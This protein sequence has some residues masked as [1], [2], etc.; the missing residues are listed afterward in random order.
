MS[1]LIDL[2]LDL[3]EHLLRYLTVTDIAN[4]SVT[5]KLHYEIYFVKLLP[6]YEKTIPVQ[7]NPIHQSRQY[8]NI[9]FWSGGIQPIEKITICK[10]TYM[11]DR[12]RVLWMMEDFDE[13]LTIDQ[14]IEGRYRRVTLKTWHTWNIILTRRARNASG[15]RVHSIFAY[16]H[17]IDTKIAIKALSQDLPPLFVFNVACKYDD[18]KVYLLQNYPRVFSNYLSAIKLL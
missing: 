10:L 4:I 1:I 11:L 12:K 5:S 13:K 17:S 16:M 6:F 8:K 15:H 14:Y 3:Q 18:V 2:D 9:R 7:K